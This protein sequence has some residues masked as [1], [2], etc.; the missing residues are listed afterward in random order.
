[1]YIGD[2]LVE[3]LKSNITKENEDKINKYINYINKLSDDSST[4]SWTLYPDRM[5]R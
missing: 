3:F 4:L 2:E 5:G 1:M